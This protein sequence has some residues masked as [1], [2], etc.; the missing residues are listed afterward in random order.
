MSPQCARTLNGEAV[1]S[2]R[3]ARYA[4]SKVECRPN[5]PVATNSCTEWAVDRRCV[6][7]QANCRNAPIFP[8][9]SVFGGMRPNRL[10]LRSC[11]FPFLLLPF[12]LLSLLALLSP[13]PSSRCERLVSAAWPHRAF[14]DAWMAFQVPARPPLRLEP[15]VASARL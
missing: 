15:A 9:T 1:E 2:P 13:P 5:L 12:P 14:L 3:V 11:M 6:L 10:S 8:D 4:A 7:H